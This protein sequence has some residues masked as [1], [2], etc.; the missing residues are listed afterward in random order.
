MLKNVF[1]MLWD[2]KQE[3]ITKILGYK[4]P[5]ARVALVNAI[6]YYYGEF[7]TWKYPRDNDKIYSSHLVEGRLLYDISDDLTLYTVED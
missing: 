4:A 5:S 2:A 1:V 7:N 3:R 6:E